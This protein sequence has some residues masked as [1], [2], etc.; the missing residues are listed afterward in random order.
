MEQEVWAKINGFEEYEVSNMG[1]VRKIKY[2]KPNKSNVGK[3]SVMSLSKNGKSSG[4]LLHR[5][6]AEAFIPNPEKKSQVNHKNGN[7]DDNRASELEWMTRRENIDH[8]VSNRLH[9]K[10]RDQNGELN[11]ANKLTEHQVMEIVL[12][13]K[14][15]MFTQEGLSKKYSVSVCNINKI[16]VGEYWTHVTGGDVIRVVRK[17]SKAIILDTQTGVYYDSISQAAKSKN[18][19]TTTLV[20]QLNGTVNNKTSFIRT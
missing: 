14:T 9:V 18:I 5:L 6:V 3:Y 1:R 15:G 8:A 19:P 2:L 4:F 10:K 20:S 11:S 16:L 13:Y 17:N 7:K 12:L